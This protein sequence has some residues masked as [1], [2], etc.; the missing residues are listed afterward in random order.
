MVIAQDG[1][2]LFLWVRHVWIGEDVPHAQISQGR[3]SENGDGSETFRGV[4]MD[5]SGRE[6]TIVVSVTSGKGWNCESRE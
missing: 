1:S 2:N 4:G 5:L 3:V 6:E